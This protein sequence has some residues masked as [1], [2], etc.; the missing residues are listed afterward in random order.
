MNDQYVADKIECN[1][2]NLLLDSIRFFFNLKRKK[3]LQDL[4]LRIKIIYTIGL[5][6]PRLPLIAW[7]KCLVLSQLG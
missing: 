7:L 2:L 5:K 1:F 6:L 4:A 3:I